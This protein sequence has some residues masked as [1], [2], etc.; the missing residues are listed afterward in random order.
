MVS[1]YNKLEKEG[2]CDQKEIVV[3]VALGPHTEF[4]LVGWRGLG[5]PV[6]RKRL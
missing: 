3:E 2:T 6:V 5:E 1:Q 4:S